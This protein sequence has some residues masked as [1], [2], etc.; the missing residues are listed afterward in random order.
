MSWLDPAFALSAHGTHLPHTAKLSVFCQHIF[1]SAFLCLKRP[2]FH[3]D[4]HRLAVIRGRT[5]QRHK[6]LWDGPAAFDRL[7]LVRRVE[8]RRRHISI[9]SSLNSR[10]Q[11]IRIHIRPTITTETE[12]GDQALRS[13]TQWLGSSHPA[14]DNLT[15]HYGS[16]TRLRETNRCWVPCGP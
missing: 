6:W 4:L 8:N 13:G 5:N 16:T 12:R 10:R 1:D 11:L 7:K 2:P 3:I 15:V 14:P 9:Q